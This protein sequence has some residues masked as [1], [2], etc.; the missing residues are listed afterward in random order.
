MKIGPAY[1]V[2]AV[3]VTVLSALTFTDPHSGWVSKIAMMI[4]LVACGY[5][6]YKR[7][8]SSQ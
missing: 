3:A 4:A 7:I 8:A 2:Q 1:I 5:G 6:I